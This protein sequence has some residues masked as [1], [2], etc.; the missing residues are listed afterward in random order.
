MVISK[1]RTEMHG[2]QN[3]EKLQL[4]RTSVTRNSIICYSLPVPTQCAIQSLLFVR[5][6]GILLQAKHF[7][8]RDIRDLQSLFVFNNSSY[9][10]PQALT[11]SK[12]H[13]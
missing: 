6:G 13:P 2:Q 9:S 11:E 1:N 5:Q 8:T 10:M 3:I 12:V 4:M 7:T